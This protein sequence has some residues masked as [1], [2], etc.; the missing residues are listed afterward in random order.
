MKRFMSLALCLLMIIALV[1]C[2]S[3]KRKIIE[4]TLSTED[5]EAILAAA[6]IRLPDVEEA[7]AAG[8][9]IKWFSWFDGFHNYD[10]DEVVNT[11][12]WTFKE[13]YGCEIEWVQTTY[14]TCHD[15]LAN[16]VISSTPPDFYSAYND[17]FPI[18]SIK[19][20]FQ[21]VDEYIDYD[22]PL[23]SEVKPFVEKYF[24]FGDN[25]YIICC[26][27]D[28]EAV[29]PYNRRIMDE[30][31]FDDP[32]EL[33]FN[34]E[35]T[36][37]VFY[38]MCVEFSDP[39]A[40]RFA[41]DGWE[42]QNAI[43]DSCGITP[44]SLDTNGKFVSNIDD[45]RLE[46]AAELLY[47]LAKNDCFYHKGGNFSPRGDVGAGMK[48]GL[49]LFW[50]RGTWAFTGTVESISAVWGDMSAEELMFA[51]MPRD[52]AGDGNYYIQ[53]QAQGYTIIKGAENP[54]G[55]ALYAMCERFKIVDPT[56]ISIDE[57]QLKEIYLWTDEM[58][59]MY[60]ECK[61]LSERGDSTIM[62]YGSGV[63]DSISKIVGN[64]KSLSRTSADNV[65]TWAQGKERNMDALNYYLDELNAN[66]EEYMAE[67][68]L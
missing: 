68:G 49:V 62:E 6:G 15:D 8:T 63:G 53:A 5:S 2:G 13:K 58:L 21:C 3:N 22:D 12:Y 54:H 65:S 47:N 36:W 11:G 24:S 60:A 23:W 43:M 56:V 37:D 9:T 7:Q 19:G 42:Y 1:G 67:N 27:T 66:I 33:Y 30:W 39:D 51:P 26:D 41:L 55:V 50:P 46:R 64:L 48:D 29:M 25:H 16:L 32:A 28:F 35:W 38:Q 57:R 34:D 59:Q 61:R 31:G 52:P 4:I 18:N 20:M 40:D 14:N 10:E 17:V 44:V 45:P